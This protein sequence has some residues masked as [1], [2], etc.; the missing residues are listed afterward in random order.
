[1]FG[2]D[3]FVSQVTVTKTAGATSDN[4]AGVTDF[5]LWFAKR[6]ERLKFR[7]ILLDKSDAGAAGDYKH[8]VDEAGRVS[9]GKTESER[10]GKPAALTATTSQRPPGSDP[11]TVNGRV[12]TPGAAQFWKT[13]VQGLERLAKASR[14][15]TRENSLRYIRHL[16]DYPV[17]EINNVWSDIRC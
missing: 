13:S 16:N 7:R 2:E 1:M 10:Q 3:N 11:V 15:F 5:I 4:L 14:I 12:F 8:F 9:S 6:K 17:I